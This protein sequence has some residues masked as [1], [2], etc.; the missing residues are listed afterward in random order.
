METIVLPDAFI[1]RN[2]PKRS[3][4]YVLQDGHDGNDGGNLNG[5]NNLT[6]ATYMYTGVT[7]YD[8]RKTNE[9]YEA[10][11]GVIY[12]EDMTTLVAIPT[13]YNQ[14]LVIPE[15]VTTWLEEA[16]WSDSD[17]ISDVDKL[18]DN[19]PGVS[20]PASMTEISEDQITKINR[21]AKRTSKPFTI[22]VAE[23]NT[24]YYVD[25]ETGLLTKY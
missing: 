4:E 3:P 13:K 17:S 2:I 8:V 11:N 14:E 10:I 1:I 21:L 18:M 5:G 16:V 19:C 23:G 24:T 7:K 15:G 25:S 12:S 9:N 20:I 6:I 22:E